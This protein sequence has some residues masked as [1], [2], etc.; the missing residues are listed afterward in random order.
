M[1][2]NEEPYIPCTSGFLEPWWQI[3]PPS[4]VSFP[5]RSLSPLVQ[6]IT[7]AAD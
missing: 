5:S 1:R 3:R 4:P 6:P 7:D 2:W